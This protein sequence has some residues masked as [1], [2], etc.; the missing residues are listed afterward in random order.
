MK[1]TLEGM[2]ILSMYVDDILMIESDEIFLRPKSTYSNT[3]SPK[4]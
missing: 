2:V 3:L 1:T 4:T